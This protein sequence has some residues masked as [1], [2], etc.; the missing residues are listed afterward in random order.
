MTSEPLMAGLRA[1]VDS[2]E[3][4][5]GYKPTVAW[6][7]GLDCAELEM[8]VADRWRSM[9]VRETDAEDRAMWVVREMWWLAKHDSEVMG[10]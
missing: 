6:C 5:I 4:P 10:R 3:W 8:C 1:M 7:E 2:S 9:Y